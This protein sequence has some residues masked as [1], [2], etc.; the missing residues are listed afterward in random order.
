MVLKG[1]AVKVQIYSDAEPTAPETAAGRELT[2][3]TPGLSSPA[4]LGLVELS[5]RKHSRTVE[6]SS[7]NAWEQPPT[8]WSGTNGSAGTC[9]ELSPGRQQHSLTQLAQLLW[10][11]FVMLFHCFSLIGGKH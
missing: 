4:E 2:G 11:F 10:G 1:K 5:Q 9:S 6:K 8:G 7:S 3:M